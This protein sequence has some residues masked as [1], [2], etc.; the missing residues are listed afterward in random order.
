MHIHR[1]LA[2]SI[3]KTKKSILLLG[4]RQTGKST[5]IRTLNPDL[6]IDLANQQ[7]YLDYLKD[8]GLLKK[9]I[10]QHKIIFIDEV[11]RIPSML[12]TVQSLIDHDKSLKFY[13][14]G[15]SARKLKRGQANLLPGRVLTYQMG[16]LTLTELCEVKVDKLMMLGSLPGIYL[17]DDVSTAKKVLRS[18][19]ATYL[20][21]EIQAEA[22]TRNLEGFSRFFDVLCARS[23]DYIDFS[24][25]ASLAQIERMSARRYFDI[26]IDTLIAYPIEAFVQSAKRR[27]IQHPK[28]Y[29]F[30]VGV[31]NGCLGNFETSAD[32]KGMLFEHLCLQMI[33]SELKARDQDFRV[34]TYRTESGAEVDFILERQ[35]E[36]YA[37]EVKA[38]RTIGSHDLRGL[39]SF[40]EFYGKK[41]HRLIFYLGERSMEIDGIQVLPLLQGLQSLF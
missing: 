23:G 26:V 27:L 5:L 18:Y 13:L 29:F 21:E 19:A 35:R 2:E 10:A 17:D 15:S 12:N 9:E 25:I 1:Q 41:H 30:D 24:K 38:T 37:I 6:E 32:R 39:K 3:H 8:P 11:Q 14:T 40:S 22:L 4:P 28:F 20:K 16:P 33:C 31:L 36:L 34:S 7:T